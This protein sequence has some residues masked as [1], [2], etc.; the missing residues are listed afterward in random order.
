MGGHNVT[1]DSWLG[2][3]NVHDSKKYESQQIKDNKDNHTD[4]VCIV[5]KTSKNQNVQSATL[6]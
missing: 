3:V 6:K 5:S 1:M 4:Y 2:R